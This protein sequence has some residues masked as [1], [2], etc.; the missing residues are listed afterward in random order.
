M[1]ETLLLERC[2]KGDAKAWEELVRRYWGFCYRL[3][4]HLLQSRE[5]A[6]DV[7][8]EALLQVYRA[9]PNFRGDSSFRTWLY[10]IVINC[11][12]A[13]RR[14]EQA[15]TEATEEQEEGRSANEETFGLEGADKVYA[16][17]WALARLP[18]DLRVTFL[19]R[20]VDGFTYGEIA[21]TLGIPIGTVESRL[22][23]ARKQLREMLRGL[24]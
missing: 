8:Q 14:K 6:E 7:A 3:S 22:H 4:Y 24:M 19:L 18:D 16:I 1:D 23:R 5:D 13:K 12:H 15:T 17:R 21:E 9:L 10:R 2:R 20:E 11:C